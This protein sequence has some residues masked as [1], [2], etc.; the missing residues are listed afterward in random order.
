MDKQH[1]EITAA[2][3][4]DLQRVES[5][6]NKAASCEEGFGLVLMSRCIAGD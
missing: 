3:N 5:Q 1:Y 6:S 2:L 4:N